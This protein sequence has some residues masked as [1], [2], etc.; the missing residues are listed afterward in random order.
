MKKKK[1]HKAIKQ[2]ELQL[3]ASGFCFASWSLE[4]HMV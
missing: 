4:I 2:H 1:R 3:Y